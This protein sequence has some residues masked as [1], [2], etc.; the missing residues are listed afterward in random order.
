MQRCRWECEVKC[1]WV[2]RV[3]SAYSENVSRLGQMPPLCSAVRSRL[4]ELL[5][6]NTEAVLSFLTR[7]SAFKLARVEALVERVTLVRQRIKHEWCKRRSPKREW[8]VPLLRRRSRAKHRLPPRGCP[9]CGIL[10]LGESLFS[11]THRLCPTAAKEC[12]CRPLCMPRPDVSCVCMRSACSAQSDQRFE[13]LVRAA[14][15]SAIAGW[16]TVPGPKRCCRRSRAISTRQ[17]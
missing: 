8:P 7:A 10:F 1:G 17:P 5:L 11:T 13:K 14:K 2:E 12:Q 6:L 15:T 16:R 3:V 9:L 4:V